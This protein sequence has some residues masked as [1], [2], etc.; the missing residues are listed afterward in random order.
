LS[1]ID[2]F[3]PRYQFRERHARTID[4]DPRALHAALRA[5]DLAESPFI[6]PLFALRNLPSRWLR[7]DTV[8]V[9]ESLRAGQLGELFERGFVVLR[10]SPGEALV[11]GSIGEFWRSGGGIRK[12]APAEFA[13]APAPGCARLAW[14]FEFN[15]RSGATTVITETRILCDD[16]RALAR[17]RWY[18]ALIRPASGLIRREILRLL[19]RRVAL[20]A[21]HA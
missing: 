15:V 19:A 21:N 20:A 16:A 1:A 8:A 13:C 18:W 2:E 6:G 3:L 17:M 14:S 7:R 11:L 9:S 4:S 12:F 5:V 10:E